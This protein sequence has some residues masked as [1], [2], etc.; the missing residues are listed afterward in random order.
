MRI[1][2]SANTVGW[3]LCVYQF[4][5]QQFDFYRPFREAS[6][7]VLKIIGDSSTVL[8][9]SLKIAHVTGIV[10]YSDNLLWATWMRETKRGTPGLGLVA[11]SSQNQL[12]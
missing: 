6:E 1:V 3:W 2:K 5:L 4:K 11:S 7:E 8:L 9:E 12:A 10:I